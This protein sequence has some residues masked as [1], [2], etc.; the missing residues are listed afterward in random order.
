[1]LTK[2]TLLRL[3]LGVEV[4]RRRGEICRRNPR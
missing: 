3:L 1:M 4:G 2:G